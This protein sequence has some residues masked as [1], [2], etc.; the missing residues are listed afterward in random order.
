MKKIYIIGLTS[1]IIILLTICVISCKTT[2]KSLESSQDTS[3][4]TE[5]KPDD[6]KL[7]I[8]RPSGSEKDDTQGKAGAV[9]KI[10]KPNES[11][12]V[13][14]ES[15]KNRNADSADKFIIAKPKDMY[16]KK[17]NFSFNIFS[18]LSEENAGKNISFSPVSLNI[19]L[20]MVYSGA[21]G[22]T[23]KEM[24]EV[25]GF[26][27]NPD[28]FFGKIGDYYNYL[29]SLEKD[30]TIEFNLANKVFIENTYNVLD[31]YRSDISGYFDGAFEQMDFKN[32][33]RNAE[34]EINFWVEEITKERIKNLIG[35]GTLNN[36]TKLVLVNALYIKSDWKFPFDESF[37]KEKDFYQNK[38]NVLRKDFMIQK[39]N[40]INYA[41]IKEKQIIK[42]DYKTS[43]LSLLIILPENSTAENIHKLLPDKEEYQKILDNLSPKEVYMEIPKFKIESGFPLS[44]VISDLGIKSAFDENA[45]F[46]GISGQ[47]DLNISE[48]IQKVFFEIDE[49]GTEA[50]AATAVIMLTSALM[51]EE[52]PEPINFIANKPF[53]FILKENK[54]NTPLFIGQYVGADK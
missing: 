54:Y 16:E 12:L 41:H 19:A 48:V 23:A 15:V 31:K 46:S 52:K 6:S 42:L 39:Q 50:A 37:T 10:E 38:D 2:S 18:I 25:M 28:V 51:A 35:K 5:V 49:K 53:V 47:K 14:S 13:V 8:D 43:E 32:N 29:K 40:W 24:S 36:L 3:Q 1:L 20:G 45:D 33:P 44:D 26:H 4:T 9:K 27:K 17:K 34:K 7:V 30:M 22:E 11:K 21:A